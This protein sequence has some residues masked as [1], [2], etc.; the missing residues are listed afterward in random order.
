VRLYSGKHDVVGI[1]RSD[2]CCENEDG[3]RNLLGGMDFDLLINPAAL[4][5]VDY[6]DDH[7]DEARA[8][9]ETAPRV[10]AEVC[11][12]RGARMIHVSTD[13]VFDGIESGARVETDPTN[14]QSEYGRSKLA[15]ENAVLDILPE[16]LVIRTS[17]VFGRERGSFLDMIVQRA[18]EN[19]HV[20]AIEDKWSSPCY[21]DDYAFL[22]EQLMA[23][24][25]ISGLLHLCN[26]GGCSWKDYG[27]AALDAALDA[28]IPLKAKKVGGIAMDSLT[29]FIAPRPVHSAMATDKFVHLTGI[30]P[31]HWKEAVDEYVHE[32]LAPRL[33]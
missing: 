25:E 7:I 6:C 3:I 16:S 29:A 24:P 28:G 20:E 22:L 10:M 32:V 2:M 11:R 27:Q 1:R 17:W 31:R 23:K 4:T 8:V 33:K 30:T 21:A 26:S 13:Y 12:D 14:P 18:C 5:Q 15:G 19:D 9:N